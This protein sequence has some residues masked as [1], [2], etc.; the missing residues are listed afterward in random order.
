MRLTAADQTNLTLLD[1]EMNCLRGS[2]KND[3]FTL[4]LALPAD[5]PVP[6]CCVRQPPIRPQID[7]IGRY[8]VGVRS[9][10]LGQSPITAP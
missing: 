7:I 5:A 8:L 10:C 2:L 1:W 9:G 3:T 4:V 6:R